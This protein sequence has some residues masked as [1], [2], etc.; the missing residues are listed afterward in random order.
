MKIVQKEFHVSTRGR[1]EMVDI[2]GQVD[3]MVRQSAI[4]NGSVTVFC[5]H[6]T[7]A[8][9]INENADPDVT[10]DIIE[11]LNRLVPQGAEYHHH[12]EGNADSHVKA[13][14]MGFS[15]DVFVENGRLVLGTWQAIY[16]TEFDGP[17]TRQVYV[18]VA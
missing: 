14:M 11:T 12:A 6:T 13:S 2:T 3:A 7:A 8:I 1:T 5:P 18:R 15:V 17:R 9:T 4:A 16:L 10:R